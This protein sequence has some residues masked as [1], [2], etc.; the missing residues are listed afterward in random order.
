MN[1]FD[2]RTLNP[3]A[4]YIPQ[5][6]G[7]GQS[8]QPGMGSQQL[9]QSDP[10]GVAVGTF[11]EDFVSGAT[12]GLVNPDIVPQI[13]EEA[14]PWAASVGRIAG[15]VAGFIPSFGVSGLAAKTALKAFSFGRKVVAAGE[16]TGK[17]STFKAA[18]RPF[19]SSITG[20]AESTLAWTIDSTAREFVRQ[21]ETEDYDLAQLGRKAMSG[22]LGGIIQSQVSLATHASHWGTQAVSTGLATA[23][24]S[25][26]ADAADGEDILSVEYMAK[27][28]PANFLSGAALGLWNSR[29]WEGRREAAKQYNVAKLDEY[30]A[31]KKMADPFSPNAFKSEL[32]RVT[33]LAGKPERELPEEVVKA[34][35][36]LDKYETK[37]AF[38][39]RALQG[40][41]H[42]VQQTLG[43]SD[44]AYRGFIQDYTGKAS[45]TQFA[46]E[47]YDAFFKGVRGYVNEY[48]DLAKVK[49]IGP[50]E[51]HLSPVDRVIITSG[52]KDLTSKTEV[53]NVLMNQERELFN[54]AAAGHA[55]TWA[56]EWKATG[57]KTGLH[58]EFKQPH[59]EV[60]LYQRLQRRD[61]SGLNARQREVYDA[62]VSLM[63]NYYERAK[64]VELAMGKKD[65]KTDPTFDKTKD[66]A[67]T[68][69][70][71]Y[72]VRHSID[73]GAMIRAGRADELPMNSGEMDFATAKPFSAKRKES[74]QKK[75]S[76]QFLYKQNA[77]E[78]LRSMVNNDLKIIYL[79]QPTA[80]LKEQ[81]KVA[82]NAGTIPDSAAQYLNKYVRH[83]LY[84]QPT[85]MTQGVNRKAEELLSTDF[86]KWVVKK[87]AD[88]NIDFGENI[89]AGMANIWGQTVSRA[90]IGFS[91]KQAFRNSTQFTYSFGLNE[92]ASVAKAMRVTGHPAV[93]ENHMEKSLYRSRAV[94]GGGADDMSAGNQGV[95]DKMA[96]GLFQ[97]GAG[98]SVDISMRAGGYQAIEYITNPKY[99]K[100][101][102]ATP[103]G[104]ALR[105]EN[106][107]AFSK[108][109]IEYIEKSMDF[110]GMHTNFAYDPFG[111]GMI[112]RSGA[113]RPFVKLISYPMQYTYQYIG[114]LVH[115]AKTGRPGWA[116]E[117]GPKLPVSAQLGLAKH[118]V[119]MGLIVSAA[120]A[121][122]GLD[123][124]SILGL[125]YNPNSEGGIP[126]N[127]AGTFM[128]RPSPGM[129]VVMNIA[130][131]FSP[132]AYTRR[133][134]QSD[135]AGF[136]LALLPGASTIRAVGKL[137]EQ[138]DVSQMMFY[139]TKEPRQKKG[140]RV[141][142]GS[143]RD[144][145]ESTGTST[146]FGSPFA[147]SANKPF[148]NPFGR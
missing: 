71:E 59:A 60:D 94:S 131:L 47:D 129:S 33:E 3:Q 45:T 26:I 89:V 57:G 80:I 7:G 69:E 19:G 100:L 82:V 75:F 145:P 85:E 31:D 12:F 39:L 28:A 72:Y 48:R 44:D 115:R 119:G 8:G 4:S 53:A 113:A 30:L 41:V 125:S 148:G 95:V 40:R 87:A 61:P 128:V 43:W 25:A 13:Q 42:Q 147:G 104:K 38:K 15:S 34:A 146:P 46:K 98:K 16:A 20:L 97:Q 56:Q 70:M 58:P 32:D 17:L 136:P 65:P 134:A 93:I 121:Y 49:S 83:V 109:E 137:G 139:K 76:G 81:L 112:Y 29:G 108:K 111:L 77:T 105:K 141:A 63:K 36:L 133:K 6:F 9:P 35:K 107:N 73:R 140:R 22:M 106:P 132:D 84:Q 14:N 21:T 116:G 68:P 51:Q 78:A 102:W 50:I 2:P 143:L 142:F 96:F 62:H 118:L 135:L 55:D 92:V 91:V 24:A 130:G 103:E 122:T 124:S 127:P 66:V 99:D 123:Y 120:Q 86:G 79:H 67:I 74:T 64:E 88:M 37:P 18:A 52:M 27:R 90:M 144:M 54:L 11:L 23:T 138:G 110:D 126:L 101:G 1:A 10:I 114:E 117:N 5:P